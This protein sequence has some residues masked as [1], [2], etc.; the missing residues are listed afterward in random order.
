[1]NQTA[2]LSLKKRK[3]RHG[4]KGDSKEGRDHRNNEGID[5]TPKQLS[6]I[7]KLAHFDP[8]VGSSVERQSFPF[9][10]LVRSLVRFAVM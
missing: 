8:L 6:M 3:L 1:M 9:D 4:A 2:E 7:A 5:F 10:M